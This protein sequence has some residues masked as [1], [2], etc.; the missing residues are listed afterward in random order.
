MEILLV[1]HGENVL[2]GRRKALD[3]A[4]LA[5]AALTNNGMAQASALAKGLAA[6]RRTRSTALLTSPSRRCIET[7]AHVGKA[8]RLEPELAQ[9]VDDREVGARA[10]STLT[11]YREWQ[12]A[13]WTNANESK[14]GSE[15]LAALRR[16]VSRW[17][18]Q[19][20]LSRVDRAIVITHGSVIEQV[21]S[22][23]LGTTH[24]KMAGA[25]ILCGH[26]NYHHWAVSSSGQTTLVRANVGPGPTQS[27]TAGEA[28]QSISRRIGAGEDASVFVVDKYYVR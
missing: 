24:R 8:L 23:F 1:R 26:G 4:S 28:Y 20:L 17:L 15:S 25:F 27:D 5:E 18:K 14:D 12:V 6:L 21:T 9:L 19:L 22:I 10:F 2:P 3:R 11:E 16:R 7:A 13:A